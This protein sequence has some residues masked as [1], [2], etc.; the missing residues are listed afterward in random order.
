MIL[1][2]FVLLFTEQL[3]HIRNTV[4]RVV[5]D[6]VGGE[7]VLVMSCTLDSPDAYSEMQFEEQRA[8]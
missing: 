7:I 1:P 6:G 2:R 8:Y 3:S 5:D 4:G